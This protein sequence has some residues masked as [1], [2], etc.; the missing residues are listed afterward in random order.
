VFPGFS[1][2]HLSG[3]RILDHDVREVIEDFATHAE[4]DAINLT[5]IGS[6]APTIALADGV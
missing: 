1:A 5:I 3:T 4:A 6:A 2:G